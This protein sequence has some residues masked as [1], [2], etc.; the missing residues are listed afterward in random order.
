ML[1]LHDLNSGQV[2]RGLGL[3]AG[4]VSGNQQEGGVHDCCSGE[5]GGHE[6]IVARAVDEGHMADEEQSGLAPCT[7]ALGCILLL[8][9]EGLEALGWG[10]GWAL[11]E[12]GVCVTKLDSDV[13]KA[14]LVVA[15]G[16]KV[17]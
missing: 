15:H 11:V 12:L 10:T 1:E 17:K 3:G 7:G 16:L 6:D 14:F 2:L 5:H 4:L 9:P 13:S 8:R